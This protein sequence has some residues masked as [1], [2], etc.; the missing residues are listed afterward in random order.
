M[1]VIFLFVSWIIINGNLI[2]CRIIKIRTSRIL[3]NIDNCLKSVD[4]IMDYYRRN[5]VGNNYIH[6]N[7]YFCGLTDGNS[8]FFMHTFKP[9]SCSKKMQ[10]FSLFNLIRYIISSNAISLTFTPW[11]SPRLNSY[12][13]LAINSYDFWVALKFSTV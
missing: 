10:Y 11:L 1:F 12:M 7:T 2:S 4:I 9:N 13:F 6:G 8:H 5:P 3:F